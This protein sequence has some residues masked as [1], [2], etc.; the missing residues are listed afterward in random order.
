MPKRVTG[1]LVGLA[2]ILSVAVIYP[3]YA[4]DGGC[5]RATDVDA[6]VIRD[7]QSR[8]MVAGL[9][10]GQR[11]A[12]NSFVVLHESELG[13]AGRR[14]R[15]YFRE[16]SGGQRALDRHVTR[17]ANA[18]SMRMS[19]DRDLY[20]TRTAALFRDLLGETKTAVANVAR[21]VPLR[22]VEKP[23]A[24]MAKAPADADA[25]NQTN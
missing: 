8:L 12:Y 1:K 23:T 13:R 11:A 24:C 16:H 2:A 7:L 20:C 10:C 22:S 4:E 15:E 19:E 25:S 3:S 9:A 18:A 17:S 14:L 21:G 5:A 6:F